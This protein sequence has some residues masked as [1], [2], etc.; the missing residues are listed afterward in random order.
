MY[1]TRSAWTFSP[2]AVPVFWLGDQLQS[3]D[4][5]DGLASAL[6]AALSAGL[7]GQTIT[8]SD[9]GGYNAAIAVN[10]SIDYIRDAELLMRWSE[11]SAFGF[12]LFRTH[13]GSSTSPL[14]T[15]VYQSE[16]LLTHFAEFASI[17]ANLSEFRLA[18]MA[19]A[20]DKG[21]PM[22]R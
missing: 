5:F 18:L 2:S 20:R 13:I 10:G 7:T 16:D 11:F 14:V 19:E 12:G 6:V 8:H 3:W 22:V 21:L 17:F 15:Q 4:R 9:I 1:F